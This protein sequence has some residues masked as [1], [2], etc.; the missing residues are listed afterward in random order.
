MIE[1]KRL[2]FIGGLHRSGTT[3]LARLIAEHPDVSGFRDT[4][5]SEDEGQHLQTVY[6]TGQA[7]GGAGRFA[8]ADGARMT[9]SDDAAD[10]RRRLSEQW[11][12]HWDLTRRYLVEKSPPNL[13]RMRY[14]QSVFPGC[15]QMVVLRHPL[16]VAMSTH[17]W[18][19]QSFDELIRHW[20][21]AYDIAVED[22]GQVKRLL[23]VTYE[24]LTADP[25]G[26]LRRI[27]TWLGLE[28]P[29]APS[30]TVESSNPTYLDRW[31][32]G[33]RD[34][35]DKREKARAL[36]ERHE[37]AMNRYGYSLRA[38]GRFPD[39]L[40]ALFPTLATRG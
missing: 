8:F 36:V 27:L 14:L 32:Q 5:V 20:L 3:L 21:H 35:P 16:V 23:A 30:R 26:V 19:G 28:D 13:I 2:V 11:G 22:A 6:P 12:P 38:V 17:K 31:L 4:G 18:T 1:G 25:V 10:H 33:Q 34:D 24:A 29:P 40:S 39:D 15:R 37:H 7:F 9:E